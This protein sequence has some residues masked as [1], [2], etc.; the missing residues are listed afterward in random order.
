M[1]GHVRDFRLKSLFSPNISNKIDTI[2]CVY[3]SQIH[4]IKSKEEVKYILHLN[5]ENAFAHTSKK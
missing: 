3:N 5:S 4:Y 1:T 2:Q